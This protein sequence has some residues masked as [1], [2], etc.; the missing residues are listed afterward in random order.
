MNWIR[1][2]AVRLCPKP[3]APVHCED[4]RQFLR[5]LSGEPSV[6]FRQAWGCKCPSSWRKTS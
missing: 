2:V 1:M 5:E 4:L 6:H 3:V